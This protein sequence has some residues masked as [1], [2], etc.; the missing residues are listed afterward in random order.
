MAHWSLLVDL[1]GRRVGRG[2]RRRDDGHIGRVHPTTSAHARLD[3]VG[4]AL[5]GAG[6]ERAPLAAQ[7]AQHVGGIPTVGLEGRERDRLELGATRPRLDLLV[8]G[9]GES[10]LRQRLLRLIADERLLAGRQGCG[11]VPTPS[12]QGAD[13]AAGGERGSEHEEQEAAHAP[14]IERRTIPANAL[15]RGGSIPVCPYHARMQREPDKTD[16]PGSADDPELPPYALTPPTVQPV[17]IPRA[18][19]DE[20]AVFVVK[21]LQSNGHEAYLVGGCVRD[22]LAGLEPKDYDVATDAYPNRIKRLFRSARVIGRR[23][24]LVHVRFPGEHIIETATFRGD[25]AFRSLPDPDRDPRRGDGSRRGRDWRQSVENIFG[26]GPED[27]HRRDFTI[28]AL[29]YDPVHGTVIDHVGGLADME[30]GIIRAIGDPATRIHEDPVRM[31]RAVHFARRMDFQLED[32]L[33]DA[34]REH[35]G[36]LEHAS[37]AR[38]YIELVKVLGRGRAHATMKSLQGLGVLPVWLP[39]LS[40]TLDMEGEWPTESAGTHEEASQGEPEDVPVAHATWNLLGAAD[41]YGL[42]AHGASEALRLAVLFGPWIMDSWRASGRDGFP[43]F[44]EHVDEMFRPVALRMSIPRAVSLR[45]R[46][47][48]WLQPALRNPPQ[49][50]KSLRRI[51]TR[52]AFSEALTLFRLGL[53]ARDADEAPVDEWRGRAEEQ[54]VDPDKVPPARAPRERGGRGRRGGRGGEGAGGDD[55]RANQ[56]GGRGR[57]RGGRRQ[58]GGRGRQRGGG[59]P[60]LGEEAGAWSPPPEA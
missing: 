20:H 8:P 2:I 16:P 59:R 3:E 4:D 52:H 15:I 32:G 23:F 44:I 48:L 36:T 50:D 11:R 6:A 49:R 33:N 57:R 39:E 27:A 17:E 41:R 24:R 40:E 54:G 26:T 43:A 47:M 58:R 35:A 38:L 45:M 28:N 29:F 25:P 9:V 30:A 60:P 21:R 42:A 55:G 13:P 51:M 1:E 7:L 5:L 22:L 31:L 10:A 46:E 34:I 53:M 14:S 19:L 12:V 37:Q 18:V 56:R